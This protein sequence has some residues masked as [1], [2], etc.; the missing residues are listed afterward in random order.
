PVSARPAL[1]A[2][3]TLARRARVGA[4]D[5]PLRGDEA[6]ARARGGGARRLAPVGPGEAPL[7]EPGADPADPR[8]LDRQVHRAPRGGTHRPQERVGGNRMITT[9][10]T[11]TQ[12]YQLFIKATPE[13]IWEAITT[14]EFTAKYFHGSLVDT[15]L[16]PGA[17]YRGWSPD[18]T[19]QW[20]E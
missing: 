14:P 16:E 9:T 18:R 19:Q 1:R 6:P 10:A 17:T 3:R 15:T 12:V 4:R 7:P 5:D 2:R 8:P 20:V 13:A 11:T